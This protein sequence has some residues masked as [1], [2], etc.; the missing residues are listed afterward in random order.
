MY[1]D[2]RLRLKIPGRPNSTLRFVIRLRV[3]SFAPRGAE[4]ENP[5]HGGGCGSR[6]QL[7]RKSAPNNTR[8][9]ARARGGGFGDGWQLAILDITSDSWH[10]VESLGHE[11]IRLD[12]KSGEG[13]RALGALYF[14]K[15]D[16]SAAL[17]RGIRSNRSRWP[18]RTAG[19]LCRLDMQDDRPTGHG[20]LRWYW[21]SKQWQSHPAD[22]ESILG[23][24]WSDLVE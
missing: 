21:I 23:D 15:G 8:L 1:R 17:Q 4:L 24:C 9:C 10:G 19:S 7:L 3:I 18:W 11:A 6:D 16:F 2:T 12:P 13:H 14:E 22:D 5:S 20:F